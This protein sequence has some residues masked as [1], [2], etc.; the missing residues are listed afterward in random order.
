MLLALALDFEEASDLSLGVY[1]D[2]PRYAP[3]DQRQRA[4]GTRPGPNP[5][6]ADTRPSCGVAKMTVDN[7]L[8]ILA[9]RGYLETGPDPA[10]SRGRVKTG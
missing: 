4:A 8:R 10:G 9:E 2:S 3:R 5:G 7:W 1:T 6:G